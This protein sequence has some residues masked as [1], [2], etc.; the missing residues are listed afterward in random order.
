[1]TLFYKSSCEV[2][3]GVSLTLLMIVLVMNFTLLMLLLPRSFWYIADASLVKSFSYS[4]GDVLV[5]N[6]TYTPRAGFI[7]EL[8]LHYSSWF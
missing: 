3:R 7:E 4:P 5:R 8:L 6:L 2:L 1:M